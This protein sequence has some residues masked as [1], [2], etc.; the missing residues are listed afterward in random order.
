MDHTRENCSF[1]AEPE[2]RLLTAI[3]RRMPAA[4]NSD[5]LTLL[6][7]VSMPIAGAAFALIP[8]TPWA[9]AT[10]VAALA[11]NWFGDSLDGTLARV[12]NRQ[13]P[14][15]GYYVDH[16]VDLVGT[17]S[18]VA[19]IA[20]SGAMRPSLAILLFSAYVLVAAETFLA[21]HALGVFR[22]S[23]GGFGPTELRIVLAIGAVAIADSPWVDVVGRRLLLFDVGGI[24][25]IIG[26]VG[27]FV[28][29]ALRNSR[30]LYFAETR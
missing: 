15:Y 21:T 18:L 24:A 10:S 7:L 14:R 1:L 5:H 17:A 12:R 27:A 29:S 20:A 2:R 11:A 22:I 19:G 16:V 28:L 26:L 9:A 30:A 8:R 3:A 4:I 13:R 23:F 6:G 25:A